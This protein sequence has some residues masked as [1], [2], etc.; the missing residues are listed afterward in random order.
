MSALLDLQEKLQEVIAEVGRLEAT[1]ARHPDSGS[2][3][4]NMRSLQKLQRGHEEHWLQETDRA[5]IDVC[6]YRLFSVG[7]PTIYAVTKVLGEFQ[8]MFSVIF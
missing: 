2:L 5:G 6:S 4:A 1:L 8:H 7:V 3:R